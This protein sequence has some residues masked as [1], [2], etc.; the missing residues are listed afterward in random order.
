MGFA[1]YEVSNFSRPGYESLHNN[2]YWSQES[3][4]GLGAGASGT[5]Y[6]FNG[7]KSSALRWTNTSS[8]NQYCR[9]IEEN[10]FCRQLEEIDEEILEFEFLMLGFR[11]L[12]GVREEDFYKRFGKSLAE[13]IGA[14]R[15]GGLFYKWKKE[16]LARQK[17]GSYSL[18][19]RG[20]L[21]LNRFLEDLI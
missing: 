15:E 1:Q 3:Y 12:S 20:I 10:N 4:C 8:L 11:R 19:R 13:K 18:N 21:L 17:N 9:G 16:G 14:L 2:V 5:I 7:E 6:D